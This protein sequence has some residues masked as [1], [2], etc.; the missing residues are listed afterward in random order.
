MNNPVPLQFLVGLTR[1][2]AIY[3]CIRS[4]DQLFAAVMNYQMMQSMPH[5]DGLQMPS[6]LALYVPGLLIYLAIA[7]AV[8]FA[9]PLVCRIAIPPASVDDSEPG[10]QTCWN[11][12]M[13]FLVGTLFVGVGITRLSA[14]LITTANIGR[15]RMEA[16]GYMFTFADKSSLVT[17]LPLIGFGIV[18]M[19][20]FPRI[21]RWIQSKSLDGQKIKPGEQ[22]AAA[23]RD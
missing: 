23:D 14:I 6:A 8:W 3:F 20:R 22:I 15:A 2:I 16:T 21:H 10:F 11:E 17:T 18:F 5:P 19:R 1:L 12:V 13:I 9:A 4:I 7:A